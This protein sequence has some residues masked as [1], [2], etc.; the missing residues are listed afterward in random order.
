MLR[1]IQSSSP[2]A[3]IRYYL[4]A[5]SRGEYYTD[6]K[7]LDQEVIGRWYGEAAKH[8][9]LEAEVDLESY[10]LL[11]HNLDPRTG[12]RLTARSKTNRRVGSDCNFHVPKSVSVMHQ[13]GGDVRIEQAFRDAV[14]R[15]MTEM[16]RDVATR[17]RKGGADTTRRTGNIA[18]AEFVHHTARPVNGVPDPHLHAHCFAF[19]A[20]YDETESQ[21]KAADF[22]PVKQDAPYF[23]AVFHAYLKGN[24]ADLGYTIAR[25]RKG[26]EIEGV[27]DEVVREFSRRTK[28]IESIAK[29][30]GITDPKAKDK[31]AEQSR[32]GKAAMSSMDELRFTWRDRLT[33]EQQRKLLSTL[34][35][36]QEGMGGARLDRARE[37]TQAFDAAVEHVFERRSTIPDRELI[38]AALSRTL[39]GVSPEE[40]RVF[41]ESQV[42]DGKLL[43]GEYEGVS[44]LTTPEIYAEEQALL[45]IVKEDRGRYLPIDPDYGI[46]D[47]ALSDEQ[48]GAVK[49]VLGSRHG[50]MVIRGRAGVG[51]TLL[52]DEVIRGIKKSGLRIQP[53]AP[54]SHATKEVLREESGYEH[55]Q[56]VARLLIDEDLQR[57][58]RGQVLWVDEAGL[59]G[60]GAMRKLIELASRSGARVMLTGDTAQH[61]AVQRG[62]ALKILETEAHIKP[63]EVRAIRRQ[64]NKAYREACQLLADGEVIKGFTK[65]DAMNAIK[66]VSHDERAQKLAEVYLESLKAK[67]QSLVISPTHAEGNRV[68]QAIRESLK[69]AKKL[70]AKEKSYT[71]LERLDL[72]AAQK[73]DHTQYQKGDVIQLHQHMKWGL[74]RGHR[75]R[76]VEATKEGIKVKRE[77]DGFTVPLDTRHPDRFS[78]YQE[79]E[80]KLAKG[81]RV[82]VTLNGRTQDKKHELDNGSIYTIKNFTI[83]GDVRLDNGWVVDKK[84]GHLQHGY[85][86]TSHAAQGRGVQHV[87]IAQSAESSR[88]ASMQQFYTSVTR[89]KQKVTILTDDK[90]RLLKAVQRDGSRVSATESLKKGRE[91]HQERSRWRGR[92]VTPPSLADRQRMDKKTYRK[93]VGLWLMHQHAQKM[94]REERQRERQAPRIERQ[95]EILPSQ[96]RRA[97]EQQQQNRN[98]GREIG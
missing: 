76:V 71:R 6:E 24:L 72:S 26:W 50:V 34:E 84:F 90:E 39:G 19:N 68:T 23:E 48:R 59:M 49:H 46:H 85:C 3:A 94:A 12:D 5:L 56:T 45:K 96:A 22:G 69:Q 20:T 78:V 65:L 93:E 17:V 70:G 95:S 55:A 87:I 43:R 60:I 91:Q 2:E 81:D 41:V 83:D 29:E 92:G 42:A 74:R 86:V 97:R 1:I 73:Q 27:P 16:E 52:M 47:S 8:L 21:W 37:L 35:G 36:C 67:Q 80:M 61:H 9:G 25:R 79:Q 57:S 28:Q 75:A 18:W 89:G 30:R 54:T 4:E 63:A 88:A 40:M 66:E 33:E 11:C 77:R 13:I 64:T 10:K 58:I 14:A 62:D 98:R 44:L 53:V 31:I 32:E 15:T 51:K 82:R 38:A 7:I